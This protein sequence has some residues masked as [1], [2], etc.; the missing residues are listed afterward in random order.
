[1]SKASM[2]EASSAASDRGGDAGKTRGNGG[3]GAWG[4]R[5]FA[6]AGR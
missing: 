4:H 6:P 3:M 1:M 2:S 5:I